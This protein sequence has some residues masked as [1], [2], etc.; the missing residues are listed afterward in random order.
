[1]ENTP[2]RIMEQN[3]SLAY[4]SGTS[5]V[6]TNMWQIVGSIVKNQASGGKWLISEAIVDTVRVYIYL[7][8]DDVSGVFKV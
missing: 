5:T 8:G 4:W 7:S 6:V 1:M 3:T 2:E